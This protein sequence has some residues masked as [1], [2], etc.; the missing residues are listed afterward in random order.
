MS[1]AWLQALHDAGLIDGDTCDDRHQAY[2]A[3]GS[4]AA[5]VHSDG[6]DWDVL[7]VTEG[8]CQRTRHA[9]VR[10]VELVVVPRARVMSAQWLGSELA[11]HVGQYGRVIAGQPDF[12]DKVFR[13]H[14]AIERKTAVVAGRLRALSRYASVFTRP[15]LHHFAVKAR[16]DMQRL[17]CLQE[18]EPV[19]PSPVLDARWSALGDENALHRLTAKYY[20][21][22]DYRTG[23]RIA[24]DRPH[25]CLATRDS[26]VISSRW[27][28][29]A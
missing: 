10:H 21:G 2:V 6:S 17:V 24:L 16:R 12:L 8:T 15:Y 25:A 20:G 28:G 13:S 27:G 14:Q 1:D 19:P 18:G 26:L 3:F 23:V 4:R 29:P 5:G 7:C 11:G 22:R 9:R